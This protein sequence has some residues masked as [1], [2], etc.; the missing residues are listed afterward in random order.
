MGMA[1]AAM[2]AAAV[3]YLQKRTPDSQSVVSETS[4]AGNVQESVGGEVAPAVDADSKGGQTDGM[5]QVE[6]LKALEFDSEGFNWRKDWWKYSIL[7]LVAI[8]AMYM[9][10]RL[11]KMLFRLALFLVSIGVGVLGALFLEP[12][13]TP[14]LTGR[15]PVSMPDYI[16]P[17]HLSFALGFVLCYV[18]A[19]VCIVMLHKQIKDAGAEEKTED[20]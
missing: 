11:T 5:V 7:V 17:Q 4:A 6:A 16:T 10:V 13:F 9:L 20:H 8:F 2:L 15:L 1:V 19:T 3:P 14:F 18:L 12:V